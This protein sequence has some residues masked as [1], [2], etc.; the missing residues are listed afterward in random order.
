MDSLTHS[1][2]LLHKV[3]YPD[4]STG[5]PN[6]SSAYTVEYAYNR[7]G[8]LRGTKDQNGTV[9]AYTRD[10]MGRLTS[11]AVTTFG[12]N[13][14]QTV[15][16]VIVA[17]DD[18]GR[19]GSVKSM[20]HVSDTSSTY[21]R[22]EVGF[23]YTS[24]WQTAALHQTQS[25]A[26][27]SPI[28]STFPSVEFGYDTS[29]TDNRSRLSTVTY[30][31]DAEASSGTPHTLEYDY[32]TTDSLSDLISRVAAIDRLD[33]VQG[34]SMDPFL[35]YTYV[36]LGMHATAEYLEP[37]VLLDRTYSN[38]GKHRSSGATS[39][40]EGYYPGWD[41]FGR[42]ARHAWVRGDTDDNTSTAYPTKAPLMEQ[43]YGYDSAS[44]RTSMD[45]VRPGSKDSARSE[46]YTY[47]GLD[48]LLEAQR[49]RLNSTPTWLP[50]KGGQ[51]WDLDMLGN[52][53]S[54]DTDL[55]TFGTYGDAGDK[56]ETRLHN[57]ANEIT[58]LDPNPDSP[59]SYKPFTNDDAGNLRFIPFTVN[60]ANAGDRYTYDA[61]NRLVLIESVPSGGVTGSGAEV[62]RYDYNALHW[63]TRRLVARDYPGPPEY[64]GIEEWRYFYSPSWQLIEE[65]VDEDAG[66]TFTPT[67]WSQL[68]WGLRYIDD[69]VARRVTSDLGEDWE[70]GYYHIT[71]V[72]FSTESLI[73]DA[74]ELI[75]RVRYEAY[76][77]ARHGWPEDLDGGGSFG[78]AD[79]AIG[80]DHVPGSTIG[81]SGVAPS[82]NYNVLM[83]FDFSGTIEQDEYDRCQS[84]TGIAALDAGAISDPDFDDGPWSAAGYD[85]YIYDDTADLSCVRFRWYHAGL[86]RWMTRD[87]IG[88]T[89]S[90][91]EYVYVTSRPFQFRDP[92]GLD[93]TIRHESS[94]TQYYE[95]IRQMLQSLA[96]ECATIHLQY[97]SRFEWDYY[98]DFTTYGWPLR[99][100]G[101]RVRIYEEALVTY[102]ENPECKCDPCWRWLK[103]ALDSSTRRISIRRRSDNRNA[104]VN[105]DSAR[106]RLGDNRS[107][108]YPEILMPE[109]PDIVLWES[110]PW[111]L[112]GVYRLTDQRPEVILFHELIWH[113]Y[114]GQ[115]DQNPR[116]VQDGVANRFENATVRQCLRDRGIGIG[117]RDPHYWGIGGAARRSHDEGELIRREDR[118]PLDPNR[119]IELPTAPPE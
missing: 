29:D 6:T 38:D 61:W 1:G 63:R 23:D 27:P 32:G 85:G 9:H 100:R 19:L 55:A 119:I 35:A 16:R 82:P 77:K 99:M 111:E 117:D 49:G 18:F 40:A 57:Q 104:E 92:S 81:D 68:F 76:G 75:E 14:D 4:E 72:Q 114:L 60:D 116:Y 118:T 66:G 42:V 15:K 56:A 94:G 34:G 73:S 65:R 112:P 59:L 105:D 52:W 37:D 47:D 62:V 67:Q 88:Y 103:S 113:A 58:R 101:D 93:V 36:G 7:L 97:T 3:H 95:A 109:D 20:T 44:N 79:R 43:I 30:P 10:A 21:V 28:G 102:T 53:R 46:R 80:D 87:P 22:N 107:I 8:E 24:L 5:F 64:S 90:A 13:I 83:D 78:A 110:S 50:W 39:Q 45:D 74:C 108:T 89:S 115:P 98:W 33:E 17:F 12:S 26:L 54:Q 96:G 86:G 2:A 71:N 41:N 106:R 31:L 69:A 84:G 25:G 51:L 70:R 48:R 91:N 11:D